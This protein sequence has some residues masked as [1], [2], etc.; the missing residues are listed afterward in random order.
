MSL[1]LKFKKVSERKKINGRNPK[2]GRNQRRG[3]NKTVEVA[4]KMK[5]TVNLGEFGLESP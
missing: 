2:S 4:K 3:R 1:N 5:E